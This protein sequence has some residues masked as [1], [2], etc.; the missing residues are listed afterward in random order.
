M[1]F[2]CSEHKSHMSGHH[3]LKTAC[4]TESMDNTGAIREALESANTTPRKV[5]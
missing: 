1:G 3:T 4:S 2:R 5:E